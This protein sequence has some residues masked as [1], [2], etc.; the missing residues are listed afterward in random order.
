MHTGSS[1]LLRKVTVNLLLEGWKTSGVY[2]TWKHVVSVQY[3]TDL[4]GKRGCS[5]R[6]TEAELAACNSSLYWKWTHRCTHIWHDD[7]LRQ[8]QASGLLFAPTL[9]HLKGFYITAHLSVLLITI[10]IIL[11]Q[12]LSPTSSMAISLF[13]SLCFR[14]MQSHLPVSLT[15]LS[16]SCSGCSVIL[17]GRSLSPLSKRTEAES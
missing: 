16:L 7:T 6:G 14:C 5:V 10:I 9:W 15:P 12:L 1:V 2:C 13:F 3:S 17:F 11:S 4:E 8:S